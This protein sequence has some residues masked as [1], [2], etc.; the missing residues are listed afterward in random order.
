MSSKQRT[1]KIYVPIEQVRYISDQLLEQLELKMQSILP[2]IQ[3]G[4]NMML[5]DDPMRREISLNLQKYLR[6]VVDQVSYSIII[7]NLDTTGRPLGTII[8]ESQTKY[9]EPFNIE[10]NEEVRKK[11]QEWEDHSMQVSQIRQHAPTVMN[12]IYDKGEDQYFK[13]LDE[14][15]A[16]LERDAADEEEEAI[17][18]KET[19]PIEQQ[20]SS[21]ELLTEPL[22]ESIEQL[23]ESINQLP[24][25]REL[26][27]TLNKWNRYYSSR[28]AQ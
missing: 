7:N 9:L 27:T 8:G 28:R 21:A 1:E 23:H 4:G 24:Q 6:S 5:G 10:L 16:T 12:A 20:E 14:R 18:D 26:I 2:S 17:E 25:L 13:Q 11:Y 19:D 3:G 22:T 15:I